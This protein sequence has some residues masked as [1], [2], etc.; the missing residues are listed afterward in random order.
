M[1][2]EELAESLRSQFLGESA[3]RYINA[4]PNEIADAVLAH[5]ARERQEW[6]EQAAREYEESERWLHQ[7][8]DRLG[9]PRSRHGLSGATDG[10]L[11]RVETLAQERDALRAQASAQAEESRSLNEQLNGAAECYAGV[12]RLLDE[13]STNLQTKDLLVGRLVEALK[14]AAATQ[15]GCM[16]IQTVGD[17]D[18]LLTDLA[19]PSKETP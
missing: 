6:E 2:R 11:A 5:L 8:Y 13:T 4:T 15:C 10:S 18:A 14:V 9:I 19:Q 7:Q 3:F 17:I 16:P 12:I 1:N